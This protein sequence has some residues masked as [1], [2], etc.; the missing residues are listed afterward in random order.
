VLVPR[1]YAVRGRLERPPQAPEARLTH[2]VRVATAADAALLAVPR[3]TQFVILL[4]TVLIILVVSLPRVPRQYIDF[5]A[6]PLRHGVSQPDTYGPDTIADMYGAK[7]VLNDV[8][9]MYTKAHLE[10]T[11]LE[12]THVDE[13]GIRAVSAADA[14]DACRDA[15]PWRMDRHRFYGLTLALAAFFIGGSAWY[16]LQTAGT[17][18]RCST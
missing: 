10:Q 13:R 9:D 12:A 16:F 11:P 5:S 15:S 3:R 14:A 1:V 2:F 6:L 18:S 4:G 17:C 7:V 8:G